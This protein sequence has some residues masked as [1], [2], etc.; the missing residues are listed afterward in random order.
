M[1]DIAKNFA[2]LAT[3]LRILHNYFDKYNKINKI[4]F[5]ICIQKKF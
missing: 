3:S 1:S 2:S 4:T 5:L